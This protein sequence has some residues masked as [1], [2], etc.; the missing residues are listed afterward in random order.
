LLRLARGGEC[1]GLAH[2]IATIFPW[3]PITYGM[4]CVAGWNPARAQ[5]GRVR[6]VIE[7]G[8]DPVAAGA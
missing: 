3:S 8:H 4:G 7:A 5:A 1:S 2:R 6:G